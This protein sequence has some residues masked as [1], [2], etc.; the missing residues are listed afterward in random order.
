MTTMVTP[1][2]DASREVVQPALRAA[3]EGLDPANR[4]VASYHLGWTEADGTSRT[5]SAGKAVRPALALLSAR[6]AGA[7]VEVGV[8]GAVAV[9]LVHA[10]SLLHD[11]VM[12]RDAQRR[13]RPTVWALWGEPCAILAGDALQALA[14]QVL[15]RS[16]SPHAPQAATLLLDT[17][18]ELVRGQSEDVAFERRASVTVAECQRM[19]AGK[20]GSLLSAST[21]IGAVLAGAP[22]PT[23]QVLASYG[24]H[25]GAAFQLVDDLLGIWGDPAVTGKPV[26]A[27]LRARKKSLPVTYALAS[28]GE[29]A[30]A[31]A[32]WYAA[33][34]PGEPL[35]GREDSEEELREAA[36]LVEACGGRRWASEQA[37]WH[38]HQAEVELRSAG[39]PAE[40][41]AELV[42]LGRFVVEREA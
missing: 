13:H 10:F 28:G 35:A 40:P 11:D 37:R 29:P 41:T 19:A 9:E 4:D 42:G 5:G 6:L 36:A 8:P 34:S 21:A 2:L 22:V 27:D 23:V 32:Q 12:D 39:L 18:Q 20:T 33:G 26:L 30:R 24:H 1:T 17:I 3:V 38:M 31:L 7:P 25:L 16:S 15:L 14:L